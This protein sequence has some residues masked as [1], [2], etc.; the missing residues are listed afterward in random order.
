MSDCRPASSCSRHKL[1]RGRYLCFCGPAAPRRP[2]FAF[3]L[4][5]LLL[6]AALLLLFQAPALAHRVNIFLPGLK[7][8]RLLS[9]A[10]LNGGNGVKDGDHSL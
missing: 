8:R 3:P 2:G 5:T 7:G 1:S 10:A 9:N 6:A 4:M